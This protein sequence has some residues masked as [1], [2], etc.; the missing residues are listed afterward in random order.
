MSIHTGRDGMKAYT[1]NDLLRRLKRIAGLSSDIPGHTSL[2]GYAELY[3][4]RVHVL[5]THTYAHTQ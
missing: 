1:S 4:L 3:D 5:H 2:F